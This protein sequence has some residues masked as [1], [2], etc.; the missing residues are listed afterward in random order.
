LLQR[1]ELRIE[2]TSMKLALRRSSLLTALA[3]T[4]CLW[5]TPAL[6]QVLVNFNVTGP[7]TWNL[8]TNWDPANIPEA[9]FN[10]IA[11]INGGRT[12]FVDAAVAPVG[13][14]NLDVG[15]LEIRSGGTLNVIAGT[16]PAVTGEFHVGFGGQS[17]LN[18]RRGG[19]LNA[20]RL[21]TGGNAA[22]SITVGETT[23]AGT[24]TL[25][26]AGGQFNRTLRLVGASSNVT[27]AG[28]VQ[29]SNSQTLVPVIAGAAFNPIQ[30]TG[31]VQLGGVV[32][33]EL[34]GFTPALGNSWTLV[35]GGAVTGSFGLDT[36]QLPE[37]PRGAGFF[38]TKTATTARLNYSNLLILN[39]DR[40]TGAVKIENAVGSPIAIHGYTIAS[41][42]NV[43]DGPWNSLQDQAIT[44]WD[45]ADNSGPSRLTEFKTSG[46]TNVAVG[47]PLNL[48]SPYSPPIPAALGEQPGA[49]V[50]FQYLTPDGSVVDGIVEITGAYNNLVLTID[51]TTGDAAIQNESPYF[52]VSI[53]AYTITSTSGKLL[54]A[55]GAWNS[56]QD[57]ALPA[58]DQADNSNANRIT[59]FKTSGATAMAGGGTVLDLGAP[60][61]IGAGA[62]ELE[63][64][65]F[66]FKLSTGQTLAGVIEFGVIP[67]FE[68]P[69]G[70]Y[71]GDGAVNGNDFLV[72]QRSLGSNVAAGT[73]A[74]G[75]GNGVIDA[76]DLTVWRN[77]F[78]SATAASGTA[79]SAVP[80]P[81]T[82]GGALALLGIVAGLRRRSW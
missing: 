63:D 49:D 54:T 12:A 82:L 60:I 52:D 80:E 46:S 74:D 77:G 15:T 50:S 58:W 75:S 31:D 30:V 21:V 76:A 18:I 5:A 61:N 13:G 1:T 72:W 81:A 16:E 48:G 34:S 43:L 53:D 42:D 23:G 64:F 45:E 38:L 70:D 6:G 59:E 56:L 26:F 47:A 67:G 27:S 20:A 69:G 79:A 78:G 22:A 65:G 71:N 55:N 36:S 32:R 51:P 8:G 28:G 41:T 3:C 44:A 40:G 66:E 17:T 24:A 33:P 2:D 25:T 10:E 35:T 37:T 73:G 4:T 29:F 7:A 62:L 9:Q 57:Q 14:V 39:V 68:P 11:V 19:T